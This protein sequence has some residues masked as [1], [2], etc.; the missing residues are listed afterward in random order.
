MLLRAYPWLQYHTLPRVQVVDVHVLG[1][2]TGA[3]AK[4]AMVCVLVGWLIKTEQLPS[5]TATVMSRVSRSRP[6]LVGRLPASLPPPASL[7]AVPGVMP[8]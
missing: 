7:Q 8:Y 2:T 6:W 3:A 5:N 1:A 4:L